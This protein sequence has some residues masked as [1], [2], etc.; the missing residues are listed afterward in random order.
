MAHGTAGVVPGILPYANGSIKEARATE[1]RLVD[2]MAEVLVPLASEQKA[3]V[4][5]DGES[6]LLP[7]HM[8]A[9]FSPA[10]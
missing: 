4:I 8:V 3:L 7:L 10:L 1:Q 2:W 9:V 6:A 5:L